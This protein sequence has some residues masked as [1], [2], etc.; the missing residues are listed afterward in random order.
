MVLVLIVF[1]LLAFRIAVFLPLF[2]MKFIF[3]S[4]EKKKLGSLGYQRLQLMLML[5]RKIILVGVVMSG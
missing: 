3:L 4:K 2:L 1:L 5:A